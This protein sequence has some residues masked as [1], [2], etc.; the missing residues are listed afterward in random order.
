MVE[1]PTFNDMFYSIIIVVGMQR[2]GFLSASI[3]SNPQT[4]LKP[5]LFSACLYILQI[6]NENGWG[7]PRHVCR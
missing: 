7:R 6:F 3:I 5:V 1:Y 4:E 2:V